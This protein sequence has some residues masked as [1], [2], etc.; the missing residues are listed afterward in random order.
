MMSESDKD[1]INVQPDM[2]LGDKMV[3]GSASSPETGMAQGEG[4]Q[5]GSTKRTKLQ[6]V[7]LMT[8]L[9]VS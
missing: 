4:G 5:R 2:E 3:M 1:Q 7:L 6:A 8:S 9:C